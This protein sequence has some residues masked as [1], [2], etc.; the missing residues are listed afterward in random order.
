MVVLSYLVIWSVGEIIQT[1]ICQPPNLT[2]AEEKEKQLNWNAGSFTDNR[3][4]RLQRQTE[5]SL[6][7][8]ARPEEPMS[9][10]SQTITCHTWFTL[11]TWHLGWLFVLANHLYPKGRYTSVLVT[12]LQR[13]ISCQSQALGQAPALPEIGK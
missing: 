10:W 6:F 8:P 12:G 4:Q 13:D 11:L 9:T 3:L 2:K 5:I 1:Q 7:S